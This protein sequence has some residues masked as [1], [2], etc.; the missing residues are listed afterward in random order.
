MSKNKKTENKKEEQ[1]VIEHLNNE[2]PPTEIV[3]GRVTE[4]EGVKILSRHGVQDST[5]EEKGVEIHDPRNG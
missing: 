4:P 2:F 5:W 3:G 1:R